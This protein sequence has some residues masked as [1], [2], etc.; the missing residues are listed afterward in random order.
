[1]L[2]HELRSSLTT[3]QG[4]F[5]LLSTGSFAALNADGEKFVKLAERNSSVMML[6]INDLLDIEKIKSGLMSLNTEDVAVNDLLAEVKESTATWIS[7]HGMELS[8]EE[9]DYVVHADA[10]RINRVLY[11]LV[12][13][14]VRYSRAGDKIT[15]S[16]QRHSNDV[17]IRVA[18][19]GS[20]IPQDK[21]ETIFDRFQQIKGDEKG[22]SGSGLGLS[23]CR[24]I[25]QLHN[26]KIWVTSEVDKGS[27]FHFTLPGVFARSEELSRL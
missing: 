12:S 24:S 26:G 2:T 6:L 19:Q 22:G 3:I 9:S 18:D 11:N 15:I 8:V 14:A 21:L 1:M 16:A 20:G 25:V 4:C 10:E 5:D 23:I 13:N 17:E 27:T 7:Q